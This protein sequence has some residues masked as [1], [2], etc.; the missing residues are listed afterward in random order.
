MTALF[1]R[2]GRGT[3]G[4]FGHLYR[5]WTYI[6]ASF[7]E[8]RNVYFYRRQIIEQF[9]WIGV[10]T[11]P[12]VCLISVFTGMAISIQTAYQMS[13]YV[14]RYMVG[15][16]VVKSTVLELA[17]TMMALVIA[18]R[19]GAG[20]ASEIGTMKVSEQVDALQSMAVDPVGYL[21]MPRVLGGMI[22]VP[23]LVVFAEVVSIG[24]GFAIAVLKMGISSGEFVKGMRLDFYTYDVFVG[25]VK[26]M[27]YGGL[28]TFIGSYM[29][30]ETKGGAAGVGA[31]A[32]SS[33]VLSSALILISDYFI[34]NTL[35]HI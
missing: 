12:L 27:T 2:I 23:V 34:T 30:L 13:D 11:L 35:L 25:L 7:L 15:S 1:R 4:F 22:M 6:L 24:G 8:L 20:I 3:Y 21:M 28:I 5:M 18:G 9:Y 31:A 14:P 19:V 10:E 33:V 26:A 29:G 17:P 16:I 32:T